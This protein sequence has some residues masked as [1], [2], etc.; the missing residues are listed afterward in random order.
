MID[1]RFTSPSPN[2]I[3]PIVI[4]FGG[5]VVIPPLPKSNMGM[6]VSQA[7]KSESLKS[8]YTTIAWKAT[9]IEQYIV[10]RSQSI[11]VEQYKTLKFSQGHKVMKQMNISFNT[12]QLTQ[13]YTAI[14]WGG[15]VLKSQLVSMV[16]SHDKLLN[17]FLNTA[18][19]GKATLQRKYSL[20]RWSESV[21]VHK[22]LVITW[23]AKA[24]V[25]ATNICIKYGITPLTFVCHFKNH[26]ERGL[27]LLSFEQDVVNNISPLT[28]AL[29]PSLKVCTLAKTGGLIRAR[30]DLPVIDFKIPI[31]PQLRSSYIM[32]PT[33]T[34]E[35]VS[36]NLQILITSFSYQNSR[37]QF[38][39]TCSFKFCS[40]I[41]FERAQGQL[42]KV[43][44][45][46]Y[47]FF[48]YVEKR[49]KAESF[50]SKNFTATG[51]SR[52]A[53]LT[54]PYERA[55][56]YTN[57]VQKTL[58]GLMSDIVS[59]TPWTI[60]SEIIDYPVPALGFSYKNKTPAQALAMC[61]H[62]IGAMLIIDDNQQ[63]IT[64]VPKWPVMP[65]ATGE[66]TCDVII[67]NSVIITHNTTDIIRSENNAVMVRGEQQGVSTKIWRTG[68]TANLYASD[69]VDK[70]I[71]D[72][73]AARQRGSCELA[74][75]GN[76]EQSTIRTKVYDDL[77]PIV[78][79][80]LV[81]IQYVDSLYKATCESSNVTATIS[82]DGK[83]TVNQTITLLRSA[84]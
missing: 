60:Y 81:G 6:Y 27:V 52:F 11:F 7:W 24:D 62:A 79:G 70:L 65:W 40:R 8:N 76:K 64:V 5:A 36:D 59:L 10:L 16:F 54:D 39:A 25:A 83:V 22:S 30:D 48:T 80:M 74:N 50:N 44:V 67:N 47:D 17:Q 84:A 72:N 41:D 53:E 21:T 56:S 37:T 75:A 12:A 1:L 43:T 32:K 69:V 57:E 61:A 2:G 38:A 55:T 42:L 45:N 14:A 71:T 9:A 29:Q 20:L 31:K 13:D 35:R 77:P 19:L 34:C 26:P 15:S 33:I 51:R 58:L 46:G 82:N 18:W 4:S 68:T 49:S 73:Q 3:S 28:M 63:K 23:Q 78:P 66:A